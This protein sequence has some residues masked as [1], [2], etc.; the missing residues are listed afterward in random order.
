MVNIRHLQDVNNV[1]LVH[2]MITLPQQVVRVVQ[3]ELVLRPWEPL[4]MTLVILVQRANGPMLAAP[5]VHRAMLDNT[6]HPT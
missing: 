3:K 1:A 2:T 5:H 6:D 4:Q